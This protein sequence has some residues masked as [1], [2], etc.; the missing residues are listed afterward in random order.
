MSSRCEV[1]LRPR[2]RSASS[3]RRKR[4]RTVTDATAS[5]GGPAPPI[6]QSAE[7]GG[8]VEPF[9]IATRERVEQ[10]L[11]PLRRRQVA[12]EK[13]DLGP[14]HAAAPAPDAVADLAQQDLFSHLDP[15]AAG[16][17]LQL[18]AEGLVLTGH[19]PIFNGP[20]GVCK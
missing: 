4:A 6:D 5:T 11:D 18:L 1:D 3:N 19:R 12:V 16:H 20:P 8:H 9:Q 10:Y 2:S 7:G 13:D 15:Q 14:P 17:L